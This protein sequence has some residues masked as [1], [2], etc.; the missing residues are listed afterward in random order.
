MAVGDPP[1]T[2]RAEISSGAND[3]AWA[4]PAAWVRI[5]VTNQVRAM[6][7]GYG[8]TRAYAP[9]EPGEGT[10]LVD[11]ANGYLDPTNL[12]SPYLALLTPG[13]LLRLVQVRSAD[14]LDNELF[15][16]NVKTWPTRWSAGGVD[17]TT[18]LQLVDLVWMLGATEA[19][20]SLVSYELRRGVRYPRPSHL[21]MLRESETTQDVVLSDDLTDYEATPIGAPAKGSG[22]LIPYSNVSGLKGGANANKGGGYV[23]LPQPLAPAPPWTYL[24]VVSSQED[25]EFV[26]GIQENYFQP[27][28][29]L[30]IFATPS[31]TGV[32][33]GRIVQADGAVKAVTGT[34]ALDNQLPHL[35]AMTDTGTALTVYVDAVS[36]GSIVH[37]TPQQPVNSLLCA[38]GAKAEFAME[39]IWGERI[40]ADK[41]ALI[42]EDV[43]RPWAT[44]VGS[45]RVVALLAMSLP[46]VPLTWA[47]SISLSWLPVS[48]RRAPL[49]DILRRLT[50][51]D[52][53]R[54]WAEAGRVQ[55]RSRTTAAP[56]P[57]LRLYGTGGVPVADFTMSEGT[58][59]LVT[60]ARLETEAGVVEVY[61]D[62]AA[63]ARHGVRRLPSPGLLPLKNPIDLWS[64]A[65]RIVHYRSTLKPYTD[66]IELMPY[67]DGVGFDATLATKL[68]DRIDH[69]RTL[70]WDGSVVTEQLEVVG[71]RHRASGAGFCNWSTAL[72]TQ[73][74]RRQRLRLS[75]SNVALNNGATTPDSVANSVT[76]DLDLRCR[77]YRNDWAGAGFPMLIGK[78]VS[79]ESYLLHFVGR[80]PEFVWRQTDGVR[81]IITAPLVARSGPRPVWLRATLKLAAPYQARLFQSEDGNDWRLIKETN[82]AAGV[83]T[84]LRDTALPLSIGIELANGVRQQPLNGRVL[85]AEIRNGIDGPVAVRF[86]PNESSG[87]AAWVA[88]TG[89][90]WTVGSAAAVEAW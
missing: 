75:V 23:T 19:P 88:S 37:T 53:G 27:K 35:L 47:T 28:V 83:A 2:L 54:M 69:A 46:D 58:D 42:W 21:F 66:S 44:H 86:D 90:T 7:V 4:N 81:G 55:W 76:G 20:E 73:P 72:R 11:N 15:R 40:L 14:G 60:V 48:L 17:V 62:T 16:A 45:Q 57:A 24:F 59:E 71:F 70:P 52:D 79:T 85:Y 22:K 80:Q 43:Q 38:Y 12:A 1:V 13:R 49:L 63:S 84:S 74:A 89:E 65:E 68:Y 25:I 61:E 32:C 29:R 34:A 3:V 18:L 36:I 64:L 87:G 67:A 6:D 41:Q 9:V 56:N 51:A 39:C 26:I 5:D 31:A 30:G 82:G 10:L 77:F 78:D 33:E 50:Y 8:Q